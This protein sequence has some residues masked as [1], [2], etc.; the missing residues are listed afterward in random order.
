[1]YGEKAKED[2]HGLGEKPINPMAIQSMKTSLFPVSGD[3]MSSDLI[4]ANRS[5]RRQKNGSWK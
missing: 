5:R 2:Y 3:I 1:M 4:S